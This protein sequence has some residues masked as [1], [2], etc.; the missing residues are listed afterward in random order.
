LDDKEDLCIFDPQ[1]FEDD[2]KPLNL[3]KF[4]ISES[5]LKEYALIASQLR[6]DIVRR[7]CLVSDDNDPR[8]KLA[9]Q[10]YQRHLLNLGRAYTRNI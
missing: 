2:N 10:H 8:E 9:K 3:N 4:T 1:Q 5:K 6:Q 7:T